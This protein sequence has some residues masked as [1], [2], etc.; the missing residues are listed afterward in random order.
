M[1]AAFSIDGK[2][3]PSGPIHDSSVIPEEEYGKEWIS[4]FL[5]NRGR[6]LDRKNAALFVS[7][8]MGGKYR[9]MDATEIKGGPLG[10]FKN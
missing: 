2:I 5:T 1:Q 9:S 4:G 7:G 10:Q 3:Y 8:E 6:F